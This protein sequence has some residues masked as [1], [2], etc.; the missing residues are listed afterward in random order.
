MNLF[1][2]AGHALWTVAKRSTALY[3]W[4]A[5]SFLHT[6]LLQAIFHYEICVRI[7]LRLWVAYRLN[8]LG[9][10]SFLIRLKNLELRSRLDFWDTFGVLFPRLFFWTY[11]WIKSPEQNFLRQILPKKVF[12]YDAEN[13]TYS[14][15]L[16]W[17][18]RKAAQFL[19]PCSTVYRIV[20]LT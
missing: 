7:Y 2:S 5:D 13:Y 1:R 17:L 11:L 3:K 4:Y 18:M 12:L 8:N 20:G 16:F 14:I 9:I 19:A 15:S 6:D 10:S